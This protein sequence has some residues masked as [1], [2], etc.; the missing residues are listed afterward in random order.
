MTVDSEEDVPYMHER[1][2]IESEVTP[3]DLASNVAQ[4]PCTF[5]SASSAIGGVMLGGLFGGGRLS[6]FPKPLQGAS[7]RVHM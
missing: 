6:L 5:E 7:R 2:S 3:S 4:P 1:A